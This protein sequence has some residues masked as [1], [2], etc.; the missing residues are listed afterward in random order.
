MYFSELAVLDLPKDNL[1]TEPFYGAATIFFIHDPLHY[2]PVIQDSSLNTEY[3]QQT[4][5]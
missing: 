2:S 1:N 3:L 5:L 4:F